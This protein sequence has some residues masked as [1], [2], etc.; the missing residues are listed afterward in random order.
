MVRIENQ[1]VGFGEQEGA[2]QREAIGKYF[3]L[4]ILAT[5]ELGLWTSL[6]AILISIPS[7]TNSNR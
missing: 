7:L 2:V 1:K 5:V 3:A 4:I 6:H